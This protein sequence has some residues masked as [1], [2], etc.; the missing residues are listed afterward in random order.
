VDSLSCVLCV[1]WLKIRPRPGHAVAVGLLPRSLRPARPC[2][3]P[4]N[5]LYHAP[6]HPGHMIGFVPDDPH[7]ACGHLLPL[8]RA[9]DILPR[10]TAEREN[11]SPRPW[12][13]E[14]RDC[15]MVSRN[16]ENVQR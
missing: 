4:P 2:G 15:R 16:N 3:Q 14:R 7:P 5:N 6:P 11:R 8:P 1:S 12:K 9:K 10:C 13:H